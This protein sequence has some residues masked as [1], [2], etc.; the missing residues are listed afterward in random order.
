MVRETM[1]QAGVLPLRQGAG[2][3][4]LCVAYRKGRGYPADLGTTRHA[5]GRDRFAASGLG[6]ATGQSWLDTA[7]FLLVFMVFL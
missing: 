2:A 5:V 6:R 7:L 3:G 1:A 4:T